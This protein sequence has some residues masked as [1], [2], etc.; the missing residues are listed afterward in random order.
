MTGRIRIRVDPWLLLLVGLMLPALAPLW[1]PGY[2]FDAHDGRHSVFYQVMFHASLLD[3]EWWPRW[4]MHHN[5]GMGYPTF[6]IQAPLGH[7]LSELFVLLG[8]SFTLAAVAVLKASQGST[9][10]RP[11]GFNGSHPCASCNRKSRR[12][13][14]TLKTSRAAA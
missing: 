6:L 12:K 9:P 3:G 8:G 4:A 5:Q 1:L 2:P 13:P 10:G 14:A 7:Y 11:A